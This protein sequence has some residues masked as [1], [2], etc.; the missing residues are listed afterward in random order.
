MN[1]HLINQLVE[2]IR[3]TFKHLCITFNF[4]QAGLDEVELEI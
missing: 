3:E 2:I 4:A 1:T